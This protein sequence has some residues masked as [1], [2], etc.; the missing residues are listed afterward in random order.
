MNKNQK[1]E[2]AKYVITMR[3]FLYLGISREG[4]VMLIFV[5][6]L[7]DSVYVC[8]LYVYDIIYTRFFFC[9]V[10]EIL[11]RPASLFLNTPKLEEEK[12]RIYNLNKILNF[13]Y[14][15]T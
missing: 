10:L 8:F 3:D 6:P 11:P 15:A 4:P 14:F 2:V 1:R 7:S 13:L 12:I 5:L 9:F